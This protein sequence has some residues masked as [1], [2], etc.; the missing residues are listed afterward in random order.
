ML[1]EAPLSTWAGVVL[2]LEVPRK[3]RVGFVEPRHSA[4]EPPR[5]S[6]VKYHFGTGLPGT[7]LYEGGRFRAWVDQF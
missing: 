6:R 3:R 1:D 5:T 7:V 2:E 4:A